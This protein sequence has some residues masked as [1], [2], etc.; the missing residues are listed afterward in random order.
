M[1]KIQS[2]SQMTDYLKL[3]LGM[4]ILNVEVTD[5]QFY[6]L[7][8][9][10]IDVFHRYNYSDGSYLTNSCI[11]L[12]AGFNQQPLS[13]TYDLFTGQPLSNIE[14]LCDFNLSFGFDGINTL[15]SPQNI[16]L[17]QEFQNGNFP[18]PTSTGKGGFASPGMVLSNYQ[19]SMQYVEDINVM[20]GKMYTIS[21]IWGQDLLQ[22]SP[23]P[24]QDL[25]GVLSFY[26]KQSANTIY[27]HPLFKK[28]TIGLAKQRWASNLT[29][30]LG[31]LPDGL[32][33]N[34]DIYNQGTLEYKEALEDIKKESEPIAFFVA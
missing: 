12:S 32:S 30:Y 3:S 22:I 17:Y 16:L 21:L 8:E 6:Q 27:N 14:S 1:A 34:T 33:I 13:S 18:Y 20:F 31:T 5:K 7:I 15:F 28:L 29:K 24:S 23:T 26:K 19:I 10:S 2:L 25:M 4:P 11:L 9:D